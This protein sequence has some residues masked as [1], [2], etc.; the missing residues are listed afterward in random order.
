MDYPG[1][2]RALIPG[3]TEMELAAGRPRAEMRAALARF[4]LAAIV[5]PRRILDNS[6]AMACHAGLWLA[7]NY[8]EQSHQISQC[9]ESATGSFWHAIMHRRE[10]DFENAKYWFRRVKE[11]EVY[12]LLVDAV[13]AADGDALPASLMVKGRW[14]PLAF[15]DLVRH[16]VT[17]G[18]DEH[19]AALC[20]RIARQE[21]ELLFEYCYRGAVG[22]E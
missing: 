14:Q 12:P 5:A 2:L 22:A 15:V 4:D 18:A 17:G 21:W 1:A 19:T 7:H 3:G 9:V 16:V 10:G 8:L 6:L 13:V 20:R 11:H